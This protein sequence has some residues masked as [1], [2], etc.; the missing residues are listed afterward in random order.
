MNKPKFL[1]LIVLFC[2]SKFYSQSSNEIYL[3]LKK[4]N[5]L[6]SVLYVAA[7]PDDENTSLISYLSNELHAHTSYLSLTRGDGG[8]NLIGIELNDLFGDF[9]II[10]LVI[11]IKNV[12]YVS[13]WNEE[14]KETIIYEYFDTAINQPW[15]DF[16]YVDHASRLKK[17]KKVKL[18]GSGI[19]I[20]DKYYLIDDL[21]M[22]YNTYDQ[23]EKNE[24]YPR[25]GYFDIWKRKFGLSEKKII[26]NY[27][28]KL[29]ET[30][31]DKQI[32]IYLGLLNPN[33][34]QIFYNRQYLL[35]TV[36]SSNIILENNL[37]NDLDN[38]S[39]SDSDL[40]SDSD[41]D[42]ALNFIR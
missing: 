12:A 19:Y 11:S 5:F 16:D 35:Y 42:Y 34:R 18:R 15:T 26:Q 1:V 30:N 24:W 27:I 31:I 23:F 28:S 14:K 39:I 37:I 17:I 32:N 13:L 3:K 7:H 33:E 4:L 38:N 6:G 25:I 20:N 40:D 9:K 29:N 8:Q 41:Y 22:Y 36:I 2:V 10:E 21:E